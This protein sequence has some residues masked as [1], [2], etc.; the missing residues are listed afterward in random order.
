[1]TEREYHLAHLTAPRQNRSGMIIALCIFWVVAS[2]LGIATYAFASNPNGLRGALS[3][4]STPTRMQSPEAW[5]GTSVWRAG[6][7]ES[8]QNF[9]A[10]R[11]SSQPKVEVGS[12][13]LGE[14]ESLEL[15]RI[16]NNPDGLIQ[17]ETRVCAPV[18]CN[19]TIERYK[20]LGP[21]Q[22]QEWH[23]EGR[24]PDRVPYV[25]VQDGAALDGSGPGRVF[26]RCGA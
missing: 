7:C 2:I 1:M 17:I 6:P 20:K 5:L 16:S 22:M 25:I 10:F 8:A 4:A 14:G 3:D 26:N 13:K 24:L 9:Q 23:F 19:Q 11:F 15:L 18:G 12:G 21:D